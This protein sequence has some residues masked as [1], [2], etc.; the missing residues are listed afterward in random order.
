MADFAPEVK[1]Y[2]LD[3]GCEYK[4]PAKGDHEWWWSPITKR[5]FAVDHKIKSRHT[6]NEVLKQA[7]IGKKF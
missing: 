7:G 4:R 3:H 6:A 1:R 5:H 2:L